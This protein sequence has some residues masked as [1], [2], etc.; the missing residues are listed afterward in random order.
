MKN[1]FPKNHSSEPLG[2]Q[3][4]NSSSN[5]SSKSRSN[6]KANNLPPLLGHSNLGGGRN[7]TNDNSNFKDNHH[8]Y[9][10]NHDP[11]MDLFSDE[12][13]PLSPLRL[14][15]L[16]PSAS[17]ISSWSSASQASQLSDDGT[18]GELHSPLMG[19][20]SSSCNSNGSNAS[21]SKET[22][23]TKFARYHL[24]T[25]RQND[26]LRWNFDFDHNRPLEDSHHHNHQT[27]ARY[28]WEPDI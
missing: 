2:S 26:R 13:P 3:D 24:E 6:F 22:Y 10:H 9:H 5:G 15:Q 28:Q 14:Q 4:S 23:N 18:G 12:S 20:G 19:P 11:L 8:Q 17:S 1:I 7:D 27:V 21:S 16:S 25:Y